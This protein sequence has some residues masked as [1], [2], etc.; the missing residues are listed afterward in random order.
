[1]TT[2]T[3]G[4][5]DRQRSRTSLSHAR[6]RVSR[7]GWVAASVFGVTAVL[8]VVAIVINSNSSS[9]NIIWSLFTLSVV[10]AIAAFGQ[11]IV[12]LIGGLDL[13]IPWV[14]T[15]G[16]VLLTSWNGTS[17]GSGVLAL[18]GVLC[19]GA[20]VGTINGLGVVKLRV[21]PVVMTLAMNAVLQGAVLL[22]TSGAPEGNAPRFLITVMNNRGPAGIPY[23]F[24]VLVGATLLGVFVLK[25]TT[26]GRRVYAVGASRRAAKLAGLHVN[27]TVVAVYAISG[28]T[29]ALAGALL[30]GFGQQS[31]L[32]MGDQYLL[33]SVA[34]VVIGGASVLGG[35]G[36][37]LGTVAGVLLLTSIGIVLSGRSSDATKT[38]IFGAAVLVTALLFNRSRRAT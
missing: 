38:V 2:Q 8:T 18:I 14:M 22:Y 31:F 16:G 20:L 12:V 26:F 30:A 23:S 32:G 28:L 33:P 7:T 9:S 6:G 10:T 13:S 4:D 36:S 1:M 15:M 19:L 21:P 24:W 25:G 35:R 3:T 34:A 37:Y 11:S 17:T 5:T 27:T 29:S